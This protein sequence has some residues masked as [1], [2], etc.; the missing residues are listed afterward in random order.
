MH[1]IRLTIQYD[2]TRYAGWQRQ[3][4]RRGAGPRPAFKTI[5]QE[6]EEALQKVLRHK[7]SLVASGR[8]DAGVHALAQVAHFLSQHR[9][10]T[11]RL[12]AALNG[13]L[14]RDICVLDAREA[15]RSFHA[16]FSAQAKTYVYVLSPGVKRDAFHLPWVTEVPYD[17]DLR[18]MRRAA[19][20]LV[21]R[22]DFRS[23]Q[24]SDRAARG[25]VTRVD[26]VRIRAKKDKG[27]L[28]FFSG[29]TFVTIEIRAAGFLRGMVRNI[30]GTL[31][32]IGRGRLKAGSMAQILQGRDRRLAGPCA[33]AKGLFLKEVF[34]SCSSSRSRE[35]LNPRRGWRQG[36]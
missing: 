32:D 17:L 13:I 20:V 8:T 16:R 12:K 15:G 36:R 7:V 18:A 11:Q 1:T 25:S 3:T 6:I 19:G 21:G 23:F 31:I 27:G 35:G 26:A 10:D 28:A 24:G 14:S 22:H 34:Y 29:R 33:P 4:G 5:Q 30:V 2:G 9:V